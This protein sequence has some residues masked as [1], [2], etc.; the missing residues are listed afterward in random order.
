[1]TG[2]RKERDREQKVKKDREREKERILGHYVVDLCDSGV[3]WQGEGVLTRRHGWSRLTLRGGGG[4]RGQIP[5]PTCCYLATDLRTVWLRA[6]RLCLRLTHTRRL[7]IS[8][9]QEEKRER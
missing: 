8:S 5:T 3:R 4:K 2:D 1:M 9:L 7:C 6:T